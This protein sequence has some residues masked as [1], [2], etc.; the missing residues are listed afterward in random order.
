MDNQVSI[1][2]KS[3]IGWFRWTICGFLFLATALNYMDRAVIGILKPDLAKQLNWSEQDYANIVIAFSIA[4]AIGY[5]WAGWFID[6]VGVKLGYTLAVFFWSLAEIAH[7]FIWFIPIEAKIQI[8]LMAMPATVLGFCAA[9]FALGLA[10][11]GNFPAAGKT[12]SEWFPKKERALAVGIFNSGSNIGALVAPILIP[13]VAV[14]LSWPIAFLITP[15]VAFIWIVL[16][17]LFYQSPEKHKW[18]TPTELAHIRSDP[19]DPPGLKIPW[20]T[21]FRY[22]Q[23]WMFVIGTGISGTIWWFWLYWV[24]DFLSKQYNLNMKQFGPPIAI[25]YLMTGV[26]S[27]GGGWLSGYFLKRGWSLNAARKTAMLICALCVVPVFTACSV[28]NIWVAALLIGL[29]A[30]SHQGFAANLITTVSDTAPRQV[31]A[32]IMGLGGTA[33]CVG[34]MFF[35]KLVAYVLEKTGEYRILFIIASCSYLITLLIIH[36]I[37]PRLESMKFDVSQIQQKT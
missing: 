18:V 31:V 35:A 11:G 10:E 12:V 7:A 8:W 3:S 30:A 13:L 25:I 4:Y 14:G 33:A 16:W 6:R 24:P 1:E 32:S 37:N 15:T 23:T 2:S 36:L 5:S 20:L 26:G 28:S 17:L 9:R 34:V 22:R 21:L 27:I 29:A 19:P